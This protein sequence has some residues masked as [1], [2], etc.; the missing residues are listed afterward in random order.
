MGDLVMTDIE[1]YADQIQMG[2]V[3]HIAGNNIT[4]VWYDGGWTTKWERYRMKIKGQR[5]WQTWTEVINRDV[6][7]KH[8]FKLTNAGRLPKPLSIEIKNYYNFE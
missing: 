7:W 6:I 2:E 3:V 8:G 1:D 4:I 5:A